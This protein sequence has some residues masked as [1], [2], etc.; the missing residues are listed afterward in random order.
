VGKSQIVQVVSMLDVTMRFG[1]G[2]FHEKEVSGAGGLFVFLEC[3]KTL[4]SRRAKGS[5]CES[6]LDAP[7]VFPPT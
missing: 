4:F 3:A 2:V 7:A 5:C 6:A 1:E